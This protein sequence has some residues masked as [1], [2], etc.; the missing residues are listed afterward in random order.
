MGETY[1]DVLGVEPDATEAEIQEA[2]RECVLESHPDHNDA[3]DATEQ[4]KRIS[5][6]RDVLTDGTERARYDRLGHKAYC[7]FVE[8]GGG[9]SEAG[10]DGQTRSQSTSRRST[11]Y[12]QAR[13][14]R[15]HN[16][17]SDTNRSH[18][19]H[20]WERT[21]RTAWTNRSTEA[22]DSSETDEESTGY[23]VHE[24]DDEINLE[25]EGRPIHQTTAVA[26]GCVW[27]CYPAF[28]V[29]TVTAAFPSVIN[30]IVGGLTIGLIAY[31]L[32][33]PRIAAVIFGSWSVV[34]SAGMYWFGLANPFS[35]AGL[36]AL[37]LVWVPFGYALGFWWVLRP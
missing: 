23:T 25:W 28:V 1:Y 18:D 15:Q 10:P 13:T 17:R 20:R 27:V 36:L 26:L 34:F 5:T 11:G 30:V 12:R 9:S 24:W 37:V 6:A 31:L 14:E 7:R 19:S 3:P 32:T 22:Q 33:W 8:T 16:S 35:V 2:Y 29:S 21:N 4:F